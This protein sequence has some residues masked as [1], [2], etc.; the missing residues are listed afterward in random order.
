MAYAMH[1][2]LRAYLDQCRD[3]IAKL[4]HEPV[5]IGKRRSQRLASSSCYH[6]RREKIP[7]SQQNSVFSDVSQ[8]SKS[9]PISN[10]HFNLSNLSNLSGLAQT[11]AAGCP[12]RRCSTQDSGFCGGGGVEFVGKCNTPLVSHDYVNCKGLFHMEDV[13]NF[14]LQIAHGLQHLR[15]LEVSFFETASLLQTQEVQSRLNVPSALC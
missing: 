9:T 6:A 5:S 15:K 2:S 13:L 11:A 12:R 1:G 10:D 7:L 4:N 3:A 8:S 14:A